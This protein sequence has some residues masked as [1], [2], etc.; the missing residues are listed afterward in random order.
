MGITIVAVSLI[1]CFMYFPDMGSM[2]TKAG[3]IPCY[4]PQLIKPPKGYRGA[5]SMDFGAMKEQG[6]KVDTKVWVESTSTDI[7]KV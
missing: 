7:N 5:D 2:F 3:G 4:D 1:L 6:A